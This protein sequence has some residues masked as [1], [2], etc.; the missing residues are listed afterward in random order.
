M[1]RSSEKTRQRDFRLSATA[2]IWGCATGML[3][4]CLPLTDEPHQGNRGTI[5][6]LAI[7]SAAT[8]STVAVWQ[9][10][11]RET[12]LQLE[13][14][15]EL[16]QLKERVVDLEAIASSGQLDWQRQLRP[17]SDRINIE[18]NETI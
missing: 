13:A 6:S 12:Q 17:T 1:A 14:T 15:N 18:R 7:L 16:K 5:I 8:V 3:A 11:N 9:S 4:I 2:V 10:A